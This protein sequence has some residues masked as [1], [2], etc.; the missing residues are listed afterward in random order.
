MV[1]KAVLFD[2]DGTLLDRASSLVQFIELQYQKYKSLQRISCEEYMQSFIDLDK[3][4]Y[5][6]KD[7]VY[8]QLLD[9][10]GFQGISWEILLQDYVENFASSAIGFPH[11]RQMLEILSAQGYGLG[12]VT[13]GRS[14]FQEANIESLNIQSFFSTILVSEAVGLRKPAAEIF[15]RALKAV[16]HQLARD[17]RHDEAVF[18]GDS[19]AAD[20]AGAQQ[21]GMKTIWKYGPHLSACEVADAICHDLAELP[22]IIRQL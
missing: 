19:C 9:D 14:P 21:V 15:N 20:I 18:V 4:G 11:M 10:Y 8:Q 1:I 22:D 3:N 16:A 7:L 13:N 2:L 17:I 6:W 5:V 12:L